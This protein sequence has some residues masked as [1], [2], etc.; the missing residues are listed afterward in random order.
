MSA[1]VPPVMSMGALA[2]LS[3]LMTCAGLTF[4]LISVLP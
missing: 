1:L 4:H 2:I 3:F